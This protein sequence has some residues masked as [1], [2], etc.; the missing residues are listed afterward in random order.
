MPTGLQFGNLRYDEL[1]V[2][3]ENFK[4][5]I[6]EGGFGPVYA[7][8]LNNGTPVAVKVRSQDS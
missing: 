1:E 5:K 7:G 2:I 8:K 6:A 3:T 4:N